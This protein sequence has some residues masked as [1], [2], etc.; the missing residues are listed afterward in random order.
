MQEWEKSISGVHKK[1][2]HIRVRCLRNASKSILT[3]FKKGYFFQTANHKILAIC[4]NKGQ[5]F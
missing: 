5:Y 3:T 1:D 4:S 2:I